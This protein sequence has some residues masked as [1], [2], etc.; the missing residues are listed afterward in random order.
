MRILIIGSKGFIGSHCMEIFGHKYDVFGCDIE[1]DNSN[2]NYRRV[3]PIDFDLSHLFSSERFEVC[4]NCSG[5][6]SV[7]QSINQPLHDF[8]LN[9]LNVF[10]ILDSIRKHAPSCRFINISSAAVYGNPKSLPVSEDHPKIPISP[11]GEHK[12]MAERI[13][14][15]FYSNYAIKTASL[16]VFSAYGV[17]L[18][19]QLF[20]DLYQKFRDNSQIILYGTGKESR[21]FI[22]VTDL[23]KAIECVMDNSTFEGEV[24]NVA[25]GVELTIENV[26]SQFIDLM[27]SDAQVIFGG[28]GRVGD[29]KNWVAD[30]S[31]LNS[32]N[33][34]GEVDI[35]SGLEMYIKWIKEQG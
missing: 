10:K 27:D 15:E 26:V 6:A 33:Y 32:Y 1:E 29:P 16:R 20:W 14:S 8:T 31:K 21:D 35:R 12:L 17:G 30:I 3:D 34:V 5:A 22:Y 2:K 7:P 13:L 25:N 4:I 23:V 11:Y 24:V 28:E 19:K 9:T 18:K